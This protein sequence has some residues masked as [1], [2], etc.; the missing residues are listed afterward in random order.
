MILPAT[1]A[2][3]AL[4]EAAVSVFVAAFLLAGTNGVLAAD[5]YGSG[6]REPPPRVIEGTGPE[7]YGRFIPEIDQRCRIIPDPLKN[8]HG[9]VSQ[10]GRVAV[11]QSRG[12]YA[13]SVYFPDSVFMYEHWR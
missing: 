7:I 4:S 12:L 8:L 5:Y 11:C 2:V 1:R 10:F 6:R 13:D 3:L 9:D